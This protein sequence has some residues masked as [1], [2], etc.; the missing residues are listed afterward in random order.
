M[1]W[2]ARRRGIHM[3]A[4]LR[5]RAALGLAFAAMLT[6]IGAQAQ[7]CPVSHAR[8]TQ[9]LKQSVKASGGPTNGGFDNN[10]WA[11]VV[12]NEGAVCAVTFSGHTA[13]DQWL[14]SR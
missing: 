5:I 9:V 6:A 8:L 4:P 3:I 2:S 1:S 14:G 7:N 11:A 10:E 12:N 13:A